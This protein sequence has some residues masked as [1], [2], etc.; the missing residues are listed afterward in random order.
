MSST[1]H[2]PNPQ[3]WLCTDTGNKDRFERQW[4]GKVMYLRERKQWLA[5]DGTRWA[6]DNA[7]TSKAEKTAT[8]IFAEATEASTSQKKIELGKWANT[9]HGNSRLKAMLE[10][11]EEPLGISITEFDQKPHLINCKN[12]VLDLGTKKLEPHSPG[13]MHLQMAEVNYNPEAKCP[14]W[15]E[16]L[17]DVHEGDKELISFLQLLYGYSITGLVKD[18]HFFI[19][20]GD[21]R[22]GKDTEAKTVEG[23]LGDYSTETSFSIFLDDAKD[24]RI[25]EAI[26]N[27]KGKRFTLAAESE[28]NKTFNEATIKSHTGGN[29]RKGAVI[30]GN[31]FNYEPTDKLWLSTNH[32]P[33]VK[34]TTTA[35]WDRVMVIPFNKQ[36][37]G[38]QRDTDLR[39]KLKCEWDGIFSTWLVEGAHR[40]LKGE[41]LHNR[42]KAVEQATQDYELSSDD[43][44]QFIAECFVKD[45]GASIGR[46]LV[47]NAYI[48]WFNAQD[49]KF[50]SDPCPLV[51]FRQRMGKRGVRSKD[52]DHSGFFVGYR[53]R[54]EHEAPSEREPV[55]PPIKFDPT[56]PANNG[57]LVDP[58]E[59][60][61]EREGNEWQA[62][63]YPHKPRWQRRA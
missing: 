38:D 16:F 22:N 32:L 59:Y 5:W 28:R 42:P 56:P 60:D 8:S 6:T 19:L 53:L 37:L 7:I 1:E 11:A 3:D 63:F 43:L 31:A 61:P 54:T 49:G 35:F 44:K 18:H 48:K 40:Y 52:I 62:Y 34:D 27:L 2:T 50:T 39:D 41:R 30:H 58:F 14:R 55:E 15:L 47:Y 17:A 29:T 12:G 57:K 4:R 51:Y 10:R 13:Q 46:Q 21:G 33:H 26:G 25:K 20:H 9:S 45:T 24:V 36:Y 23:L